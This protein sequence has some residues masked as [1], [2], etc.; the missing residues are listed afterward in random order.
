ML[1]HFWYGA[2]DKVAFVLCSDKF[3]FMLLLGLV[4]DLKSIL[5]AWN[6]PK[7]MWYYQKLYTIFGSA[8]SINL[9]N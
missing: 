2:S 3:D 5:K 8:L 4:I 9:D 7:V 1:I 6:Q